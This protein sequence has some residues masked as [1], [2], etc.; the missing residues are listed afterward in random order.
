[1]QKEKPSLTGK[2]LWLAGLAAFALL[3]LT[4]FVQTYVLITQGEGTVYEANPVANAWLESHGWRGLAAFKFGAVAVFAGAAMLLAVRRPR[5]GAGVLVLGCLALL[6]VTVY[7]SRLIANPVQPQQEDEEFVEIDLD[8]IH[9]GHPGPDA[10]IADRP[11]RR[12]E[13]PYR[14]IFTPD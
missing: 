3:S 2:R 9:P 1:M 5:T 13:L 10:S 8:R 4:D 11:F 12:G 14:P 7:S 6:S